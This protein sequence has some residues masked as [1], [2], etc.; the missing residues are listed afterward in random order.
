MTKVEASLDKI[1]IRNTTPQHARSIYDCVRL[2]YHI[3]LEEECPEC[4]GIVAVNN[5]L[6]RFPEGQ[7]VATVPDPLTGEDLVVGSA[8][9]MRTT[10]PPQE[11]PLAWMEMIGDKGIK[12]HE[13]HGDWLYGV[14]MVVRPSYRRRGIGTA[15]YKARFN[16]V[17]H[18]N[19]KGWYAVGMLMGYHRYCD[20][21][22]VNTYGQAVIN[23]EMRD[24]TVSMQ[25]NRGFQ[26]I[27]VV[28]NYLFEEDAGNAGVLIVW[29]NPDYAP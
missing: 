18:L 2:A 19:L 4:M 29:N 8:H 24:P 13:P 26:P 1:T 21:M 6:T 3:P 5:Q 27:R 17:R 23:G 15:L 11:E 25:V 22:S 9:T 10:R 7:F 12:N 16:L 14:E 28:E 20:Q